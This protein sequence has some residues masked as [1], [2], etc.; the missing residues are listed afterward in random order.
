MM[1]TFRKIRKK[2]HNDVELVADLHHND[3]HSRLETLFSYCQNEFLKSQGLDL[4]QTDKYR[5]FAELHRLLTVQEIADPQVG[6]CRIGRPNDGGYVMV[7]H[8]PGKVAYSLG[9]AG[10][11][12]WDREMAGRGFD[13]YMYDH[14]I[15]H[16]PEQNPHYHWE[17][18]GVSGIAGAADNLKTLPE[19]LERNGHT[20]QKGIVLKIDI[21]GFE[22]DALANAGEATLDC[23]DQI[24]GEFHDFLRMDKR[25]QILAGL[26]A[27][28]KTHQLVYVHPNNGGEVAYCGD[29][30]MPSLLEVV[31]VRRG[32]YSFRP[33]NLLFPTALDQPCLADR[34]EVELGRW[35]MPE[36]G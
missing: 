15:E 14:T 9:I 18:L 31:F 24:V 30:M 28:N 3:T 1:E 2:W 10:D 32:S 36:Q 4:T 5:Y 20:G 7:D 23:F 22:W 17:K 8:F 21:E 25:E 13:I 19:L 33:S 6:Y 26:R 35:N 16:L 29:L 12:S 27:L 34:A 11:V